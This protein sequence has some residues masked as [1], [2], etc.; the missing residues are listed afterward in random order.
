MSVLVTFPD[1]E[2]V[3][4]DHLDGLVTPPVSVGVPSGWQPTTDT[5]IVIEVAS[6]GVPVA[7]WP[8]VQY[9]TVR[10]VARGRSTTAVKAAAAEAQALLLATPWPSDVSSIRFL[11]GILPARDPDTRVE[12]ASFTVEVALRSTLPAS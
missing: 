5:P 9:V 1:V 11:T 10:V 12:V 8:I 7:Q 6:D 4:V 3:I 2:R